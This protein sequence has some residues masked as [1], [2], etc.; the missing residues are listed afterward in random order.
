MNIFLNNVDEN[1]AYAHSKTHKNVYTHK[2][3]VFLGTSQYALPQNV[4]I[5]FFDR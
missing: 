3:Y 4:A 5:K 2:K 1:I